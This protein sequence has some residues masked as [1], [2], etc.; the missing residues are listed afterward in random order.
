MN[1][2]WTTN[3]IMPEVAKRLGIGSKHPVSWIEAMSAKLKLQKGVALAIVSR[4]PVSKIKVSDLEGIK[5]ILLP[6]DCNK[7][8]YW[9]EVFTLFNPEVIH[10]YGT[11][12][13]QSYQ[14]LKNHGDKP[15]IISLQGILTEYQ[16]HYYAGVEFLDMI[17]FTTLRDVLK[18]QGFFAGRRDFIRRSKKEQE[19]LKMAK[20]VE[21]RSTWDK[22]SAL[23]IN[24]ELNYYYCPRMI[25]APFY[26]GGWDIGKVESHS[27]FVHQGNYPVKG[28]HFVIPA[29]AQ[30]K[31]KYPGVKLYVSG[32]DLYSPTAQYTKLLPYGY[33]NYL[34]Y[35]IKKYNV[36]DSIVFTG[37]LN[38]EQL[39]LHLRK[40]NV[41][42]LP[43][44]IENAPNSIVEAQLVGVPVVASFVGGNMEM[45]HHDDD[46]F[47]YCYNEPN[48][49]SEYVSRIFEDYE[50]AKSF[51][52]KAREH[53]LKKHDPG[54][55]VNT[56][57][58][59][60]SKI[61]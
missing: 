54:K 53:A 44:S 51:S 8:D 16:H 43:S 7:V 39:A 56:L 58:D 40:M 33:P 15:I 22:V 46:G 1:I 5:Y 18:K 45:V 4:A 13:D 19:L 49:L 47:L 17:R 29:L 55:L 28:L 23:N 59:I 10:V 24:P 35:L 31:I 48:M 60:Y 11:E 52:E 42:V 2:L 20:N 12:S 21:G 3:V 61:R 30:L 57:L 32:Q 6:N 50:L 36:R 37:A 9:N 41:V 38:A 14:L 34:K 25:R 27:I 26:E